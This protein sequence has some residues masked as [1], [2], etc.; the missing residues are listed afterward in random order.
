MAF[1][2][3]LVFRSFARIFTFGML[4][5]KN[6]NGGKDLCYVPM[7]GFPLWNGNVTKI[8]QQGYQKEA[9]DVSKPVVEFAANCNYFG[10]EI[11][12]LVQRVK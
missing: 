12:N 6:Q 2:S 5:N 1:F 11:Y 10:A 4:V 3:K 7:L 8:H 9:P